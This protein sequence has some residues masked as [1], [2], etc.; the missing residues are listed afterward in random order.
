MEFIIG[1]ELKYPRPPHDLSEAI[2]LAMCIVRPAKEFLPACRNLILDHHRSILEKHLKEAKNE[3]V[4]AAIL[5]LFTDLTK[6]RKS[7]EPG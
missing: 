1:M 3:D 6:E 4:R 5:N 7:N 2:K